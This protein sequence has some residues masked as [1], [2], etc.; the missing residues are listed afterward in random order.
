M[1]WNTRVLL[2]NR[3]LRRSDKERYCRTKKLLNIIQQT[4]S[5][6]HKALF[7]GMHSCQSQRWS[8]WSHLPFYFWKNRFSLQYGWLP[9]KGENLDLNPSTTPSKRKKKLASA[10]SECSALC[11]CFNRSS[12]HMSASMYPSSIHPANGQ[13]ALAKDWDSP[14]EVS[15]EKYNA[16]RL[17]WTGNKS[18]DF[19]MIFT[20]S[21]LLMVFHFPHV[22]IT[23]HTSSNIPESL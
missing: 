20:W 9:C 3:N 7:G 18:S 15:S 22:H 16:E 10:S 8:P 14:W 4:A 19:L 2:F 17:F 6:N 23:S 5:H 12:T 1:L 11:R 21:D 13:W